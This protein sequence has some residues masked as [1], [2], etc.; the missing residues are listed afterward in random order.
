MA[1]LAF[2]LPLGTAPLLWW[3]SGTQTDLDAAAVRLHA[4]GLPT[5]G[6]EWGRVV[7]DPERLVKRR[8]IEELAVALDT[9]R[10]D[11][12]YRSDYANHRLMTAVPE[13]IATFQAACDAG[14]VAELENLLLGLGDGPLAATIDFPLPYGGEPGP[15]RPWHFL[16]QRIVTASVPAAER[17]ARAALVLARAQAGVDLYYGAY[18]LE[19]V[20]K[21][22]A[23]RMAAGALFSPALARDLDATAAQIIAQRP[24]AVAAQAITYLTLFRKGFMATAKPLGLSL[25]SIMQTAPFNELIFRAGRARII[26]D[27]GTQAA[28]MRDHHRPREWADEDVRRS[29]AYGTNTRRYSA[30]GF[31]MPLFGPLF[32]PPITITSTVVAMRAGVLAAELRQGAWPEDLLDPGRHPLRPLQSFGHPVGAYSVGLD[33]RDDGGGKGDVKFLFRAQPLGT[34]ADP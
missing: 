16:R 11:Y 25:P 1:A 2:G 9:Y 26:D 15:Y 24:R 32:F 10:G 31:L 7:A 20:L 28:F 23:S 5:T 14:H 29:L 8:R 27:L 34:T 22:I 18:Q 21:A 17:A 3:W 12:D 6:E 33:G 30:S 19:R 4:L 13:G